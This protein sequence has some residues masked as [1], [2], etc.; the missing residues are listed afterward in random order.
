MTND[1]RFAK[2]KYDLFVC[3]NNI[4]ELEYKAMVANRNLRKELETKE[5]LE[6]FLSLLKDTEN[7]LKNNVLYA[8]NRQEQE[9]T[10]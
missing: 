2:I 8:N 5:N 9:A 4:E 7:E 10:K 3:K 6:L 1:E